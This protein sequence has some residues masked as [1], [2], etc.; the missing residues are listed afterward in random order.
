MIQIDD[1]DFPIVYIKKDGQI[2]KSNTLFS[3]VFAQELSYSNIFDFVKPEDYDS[4]YSFLNSR[5]K[6]ASFYF[7][8]LNG[9]EKRF[10]IH[11]IH[12]KDVILLILRKQE[13]IEIYKKVLLN[14]QNF[15]N[16]FFDS[17]DIGIV[18]INKQLNVQEINR[19]FKKEF[20]LK[21]KKPTLNDLMPHIPE[22][23]KIVVDVIDS[24]KPR[25]LN[26]K[27][28][29]I[30]YRVKLVKFYEKGVII[31]F[32]PITEEM[33]L[34]TLSETNKLISEYT[35]YNRKSFLKKLYNLLY[36]NLQI[37]NLH[38]VFTEPVFEKIKNKKRDL[39]HISFI[40]ENLFKGKIFFS[41]KEDREFLKL[42]VEE[43]SKKLE[44]IYLQIKKRE[45]LSVLSWII[46]IGSSLF[47]SK[48]LEELFSKLNTGLKRIDVNAF[49]KIVNGKYSI[50]KIKNSSGILINGAGVTVYLKIKKGIIQSEEEKILIDI[51]K[52]NLKRINTL[53]SLNEKIAQ[54]RLLHIAGYSLF[55]QN[56]YKAVKK[57]LKEL[58]A[59]GIDYVTYFEIE[60]DG[61]ISLKMGEGKVLDIKTIEDF[62][63][64]SLNIHHEELSSIYQDVQKEG[65]TFLKRNES[66]SLYRKISISTETNFIYIIPV[67][68][69]GTIVG[70]ITLSYNSPHIIKKIEKEFISSLA[71]IISIGYSN[72]VNFQMVGKLQL[73]ILQ[74]LALFTK[75]LRSRLKRTTAIKMI[76]ERMIDIIGAKRILF[77]ENNNE[78]AVVKGGAGKDVKGFL[79][80]KLK[81]DEGIL[82]R[83]YQS[84]E[85]VRFDKR[86]MTKS[87]SKLSPLETTGEEILYIP[88]G[89]TNKRK[90]TFVIYFDPMETIT[91][92]KI[93]LI[94]IIAEFTELLQNLLSSLAIFTHFAK[95]IGSIDV[96]KKTD[97]SKKLIDSFSPY[98]SILLPLSRIDKKIYKKLKKKRSFCDKGICYYRLSLINE[99]DHCIG[100]MADENTSKIIVHLLQ[101]FINNY[102]NIAKIRNQKEIFHILASSLQTVFSSKNIKEDIKKILLDVYKSLNVFYIAYLSKDDFLL[103]DCFISEEGITPKNIKIPLDKDSIVTTALKKRRTLNIKNTDQCPF[104]LCG[105]EKTKSELATPVFFGEKVYGVLDAGKTIKNGFQYL[106]VF[107][108]E[109]IASLLGFAQWRNETETNLKDIELTFSIF[110]NISTGMILTNHKGIVLKANKSITDW[111]G[112]NIVGRDLGEIMGKEFKKALSG[113]RIDRGTFEYG[114]TTFGFSTSSIMS[115]NNVIGTLVIVRDLTEIRE[116][117]EKLR[118][119]DRLAALGEMSAGMAHEIKNP[120]AA[121]KAGIEYIKEK[122]KNE[123]YWD[124]F[125]LILKEINRVDRIV[126][127]MISYARRPPLRKKMFNIS[128]AFRNIIS[129]YNHAVKEK[130]ILLNFSSEGDT[131]IY[132][133]EEQIG[134]V[135]TNILLNAIDSVKYNGIINIDI[136]ADENKIKV[137]VEDNGGGVPEENMNKI[138]NPF[139]TTKAK[140]TGL[141][142]SITHRIIT[143]HNGSI[144]VKN[145]SI[146]GA[147]FTVTLPRRPNE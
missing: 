48:S 54:Y 142:L 82:W 112:E 22:L 44:N 64:R 97:L 113:E 42:I 115:D 34:K 138:F 33:F 129:M 78:Y 1:L 6:K 133:D 58:K 52:T 144:N 12:K 14:L 68:Y 85:I 99:G 104:Y 39:R 20:S 79:G 15:W 134:E 46:D 45:R 124:S 126:K 26:I 43:L 110:E 136:S 76:M 30:I 74:I 9:E 75:I 93:S 91:E 28:K 116:M 35:I 61:K 128:E 81:K 141:G 127:D 66:P 146:G 18:I 13:A 37:H 38:F 117:E 65:F 89:A 17:L 4:F 131:F 2:L 7:F 123:E 87:K 108:L 140:G 36:S 29:G 11:K 53:K 25:T 3:N 72:Y 100:I 50:R 67:I 27:R 90:G 70:G 137:N 19:T 121:I 109:S 83:S 107:I 118:R 143:N 105:I 106:D 16:E 5:R 10:S 103:T 8:T 80:I 69:R 111:I 88:L 47:Q 32:V 84:S 60:K 57:I 101:L 62:N 77:V 40:V 71:R 59:T 49:S 147:T 125:D 102:T 94:K 135:L 21:K 119:Q 31:T 132:G 24:G 145:N 114:G 120:L 98:V 130:N 56:F 55:E 63:K 73:A 122:S 92:N 41:D 23:K 139:F 95:A 86:K 51:I 96:N